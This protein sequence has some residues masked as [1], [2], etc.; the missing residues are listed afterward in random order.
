[1]TS[2]E[3]TSMVDAQ[4]KL[5]LH[6]DMP[7]LQDRKVNVKRKLNRPLLKAVVSSLN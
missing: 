3:D 4:K 7:Q 1:M 5:S 6:L 2:M